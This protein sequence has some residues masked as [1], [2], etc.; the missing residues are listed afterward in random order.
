MF[1]PNTP[2][3]SFVCADLLSLWVSDKNGAILALYLLY[4]KVLH[5]FKSSFGLVCYTE[6]N[7]ANFSHPTQDLTISIASAQPVALPKC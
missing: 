1:C 3:E 2:M 6:A 5:S 7:I 4:S